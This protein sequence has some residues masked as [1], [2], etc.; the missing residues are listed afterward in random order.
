MR[1]AHKTLHLGH[2]LDA[3][4]VVLEHLDN[5]VMVLVSLLGWKDKWPTSAVH[6][7]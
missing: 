5:I 3:L 7:I 1:G 2:H 6:M 4:D